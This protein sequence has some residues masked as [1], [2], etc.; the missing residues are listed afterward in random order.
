[1]SDLLITSDKTKNI[2]DGGIL[3]TNIYSNEFN[4][5]LGDSI[6]LYYHQ[7]KLIGYS[8]II[9]NK[10]NGVYVE[11]DYENRDS[12]YMICSYINDKPHGIGITFSERG[13]CDIGFYFHGRKIFSRLVVELQD[14]RAHS[15]Y[16]FGKDRL[17]KDTLELVKQKIM[18]ELFDENSSNP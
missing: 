13:I 14:E 16:H 8:K 10:D 18:K 7:G 15:M 6:M 1:M 3:M 12:L 5:C 17:P 11:Y 2:I 4:I 9:N